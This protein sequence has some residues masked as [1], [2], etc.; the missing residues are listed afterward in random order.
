MKSKSNNNIIYVVASIYLSASLFLMPV[1][2]IKYSNLTF[3]IIC[4]TIYIFDLTKKH[5][6]IAR[7]ILTIIIISF[8]I[9]LNTILSRYG[10]FDLII[11]SWNIILTN[12]IFYKN[13]TNKNTYILFYRAC[14]IFLSLYLI[15]Y[16][17]TL[18]NY[19]EINFFKLYSTWDKNYS[20]V[21]IFLY[22]SL[23]IKLKKK[24]GLMI[25]LIYTIILNSR[26]LQ[27]CSVVSL[28]I[29]LY[30]YKKKSSSAI[31]YK[32]F[33]KNISFLIITLSTITIII[34]YYLTYKVNINS[35]TSYR[36]SLY[37]K[38]NAIR[39]RANV[40]AVEEIVHE[41]SR[42]I[43]GYDN[44]IKKQLDVEEEDTA[45]IY[46]GYRL[47]QPHNFILNFVLR[48]GLLYT[49]I[50]LYLLERLLAPSLN[51]NNR[52]IIIPYM[53]MNM[54]MHSLLSSGLLIFF[55][56]ILKLNTG[57]EHEQ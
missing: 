32:P 11:V 54:I 35:I 39:V 36:E 4:S 22:I 2:L 24:Y 6:I 3:L 15:Y 55:V 23:S 50:Y 12:I 40:Y 27:L 7:N 28:L 57:K 48:Y 42:I 30:D 26:M 9:I 33:Y 10:F 53:V 21:I 31:T 18:H 52:F 51:R 38:S 17:L 16:L 1:S 34:S 13:N 44:E 19:N 56:Y 46:E 14:S 20:A 47:V 41:P 29:Y 43:Y 8:I 49:I 45:T 5:N 25:G 37:D